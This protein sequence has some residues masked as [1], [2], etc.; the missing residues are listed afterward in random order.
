M[1]SRGSLRPLHNRAVMQRNAFLWAMGTLCAAGLPPAARAATT[2]VTIRAAATLDDDA[3]PFI[4]ATQNGLFRR[5]GIDA[6]ITRGTSGA[7]IAAGVIGGAFEIGKS[8]ITTLCAAHA[9]G[10]PLIWIAPA[11]EYDAATPMRL[12]MIVKAD[13]SIKTGA[14][15]NGKTIGVSGLNDI[16]SLSSRAW[17]DRTGGDSSTIKLTE[18]P[19][20]QAALAVETGRLDSAVVIQPFLDA[21]LAGGKVRV[22][23]DPNV[24]VAPHF[25]Q[26]AWF[27]SADFAAKNPAAIESFIRVMRE[28]STY[29]NSHHAETASLLLS[30][31]NVQVP[32]NSRILLGVRFNTAQIQTLIDLQV[33]YKMLPAPMNAAELIYPAALRA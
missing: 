19:M 27:T 29:G 7:A 4:W 6:S 18:I 32:L 31:L 9:R 12:A 3:T 13:S 11:G 1:N 23:A 30:Y 2:P 16:F 21:A 24:A 8:S 33:R 22:L 10:V 26:A 20:T 5:N 28:A 14:D 17:A 15:L 25:M